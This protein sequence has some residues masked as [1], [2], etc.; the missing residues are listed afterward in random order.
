MIWKHMLQNNSEIINTVVLSA[1][2]KKFKQWAVAIQK[3]FSVDLYFICMHV[4][5]IDSL[6]CLCG[7]LLFVCIKKIKQKMHEL[8]DSG[9]ISMGGG[10]GGG[11]SGIVHEEVSNSACV[12][13][14]RHS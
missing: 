6:C 2:S 9:Q 1:L 12:A 7:A 8:A 11:G 13:R 14:L 4:S 3:C 5:F 10:G